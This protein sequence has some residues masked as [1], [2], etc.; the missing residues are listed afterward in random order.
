MHV[1]VARW[2]MRCRLTRELR[3]QSLLYTVMPPRQQDGMDKVNFVM[4]HGPHTVFQGRR[5][6]VLHQI[7]FEFYYGENDEVCYFRLIKFISKVYDNISDDIPILNSDN[8]SSYTKNVT[9]H[10]INMRYDALMIFY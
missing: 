10:V 6:I 9:N 7:G 4:L 2:E 5:L 1:R 3:P 8:Y